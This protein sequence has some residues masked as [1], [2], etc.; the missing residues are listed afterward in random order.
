VYD[1]WILSRLSRLADETR[2][3]MDDFRLSEAANGIYKF[4]WGE[5]CDWAIELAKP[6]LYD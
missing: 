5:L 2:A 4:V 1:R 6:A 3:A